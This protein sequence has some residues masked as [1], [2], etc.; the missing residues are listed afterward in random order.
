MMKNNIQKNNNYS[1]IRAVV[2]IRPPLKREIVKGKFY[3]CVL[4]GKV[5]SKM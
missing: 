2:R 1:N 4:A 3:K 5:D